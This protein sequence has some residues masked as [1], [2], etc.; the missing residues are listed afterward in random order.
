MSYK[1]LQNMNRNEINYGV[2]YQGGH[3]N[4]FDENYYR[5]VGWEQFQGSN[6]IFSQQNI[7]YISQ[8]IRKNLKGL[9]PDGKDIVVSDR[10]ITQVM[11]SVY[12]DRTPK[13]GDIYTV[14][15]IPEDDKLSIEDYIILRTIFIIT[16]ELTNQFDMI[17][18]NEKL[19]AWNTVLGDF[20]QNGLRSH[21]KIK[22]RERDINNR[23]KIMFMNY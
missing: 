16:N 1:N 8:Q 2:N 14:F 17:R 13:F 12:Q 6:N 7:D 21:S 5:H 3:Q 15:Q 10:S 19:T 22:T 4:Y 11:S 9:G 20:N 18:Q 23:G